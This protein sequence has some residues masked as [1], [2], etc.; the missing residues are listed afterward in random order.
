MSK[1]F[2]PFTLKGVKVQAHL[3]AG[4]PVK[5]YTRNSAPKNSKGV[6]MRSIH[7]VTSMAEKS[8]FIAHLSSKVGRLNKKGTDVIFNRNVMQKIANARKNRI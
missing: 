7:N 5:A 4:K 3:R 8:A 1:T 6:T 2:N